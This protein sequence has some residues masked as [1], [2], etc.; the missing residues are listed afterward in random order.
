MSACAR[1]NA[2]VSRIVEHRWRGCKCVIRGDYTS[3]RREPMKIYYQK[4]RPVAE[5]SGN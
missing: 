1:I 2:K 3:S 5:S 4:H